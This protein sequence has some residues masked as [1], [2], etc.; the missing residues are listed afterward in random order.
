MT[1]VAVVEAV[2]LV[3]VVLLFLHHIRALERACARERSQLADRIQRPDLLP[4]REATHFVE[5]AAKEDDELSMVGRIRISD[6]YS[7]DV[8][9]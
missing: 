7:G 1:I 8:N 3:A 6:S 4:V 9:G 2:A 5:P